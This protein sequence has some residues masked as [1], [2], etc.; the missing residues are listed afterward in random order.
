MMKLKGAVL[1]DVFPSYTV[2]HY[3]DTLIILIQLNYYPTSHAKANRQ[4]SI[5]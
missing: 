1:S 4:P 3:S 2:R 5:T